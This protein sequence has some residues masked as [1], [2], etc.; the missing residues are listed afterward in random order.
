[1][2]EKGPHKFYTMRGYQLQDQQSH[3]LTPSL[4]DY[5][6]MIFRSM[7]KGG[8]VRVSRLA[9]ELNVKPS[10]VSKMLIKLAEMGYV[11]YEKYGEIRLTP[12]GV[13]RGGYLLWRH[14]VVARFFGAIM[15][16]SEQ[17]FEEVEL[18]EHM[19]SPETV[20]GLERATRILENYA[21]KEK[22]PPP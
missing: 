3:A 17:A 1:M 7:Q 19:L 2:E 4:E 5:L 10:S 11:A 8:A 14:N 9:E 15:P 20:R 16:N 6:E 22:A 18:V 12:K 13:E 21:R